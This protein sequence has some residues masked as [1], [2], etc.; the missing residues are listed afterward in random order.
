MWIRSILFFLPFFISVSLSANQNSIQGNPYPI[1]AG[2]PWQGTVPGSIAYTS[3]VNSA[4]SRIYNV[5]I[6]VPEG[7]NGVQPSLFL[8]YNNLQA[9]STCG[10]GWMLS[11]LSYITRANKSIHFDQYA[12]AVYF[13]RDDAFS[14]D[15]KRLI[16]LADNGDNIEYETYIGKIRAKAYL[17]GSVVKYFEV[18]YPDGKMAVF[19]EK[20]NTSNLVKYDVTS[21]SDLLGNTITYD[22]SGPSDERLI[23]A[24][25]YNHS[26]I[27]FD[28]TQRSDNSFT[29]KNGQMFSITKLLKS[30]S[31]IFDGKK[32]SE[33]SL[34][35]D[36]C[37]GRTFLKQIDYIAGGQRLNPLI[38]KYGTLSGQN[39]FSTT[40]GSFQSY[41]T[42]DDSHPLRAVKGRFM[43]GGK[44]EGLAVFPAKGYH[45][46]LHST[47]FRK[48]ITA[49]GI[50][51]EGNEDIYIYPSLS[52]DNLKPKVIKA[53]K[54]FVDLM[55]VNMGGSQRE[56]LVKINDNTGPS[57]A[58]YFNYIK[59]KYYAIDNISNLI[60]NLIPSDSVVFKT[61]TLFIDENKNK[62][63]VPKYFYS[64]D[65][66]GDG[67]LES[68]FVSVH[69]P[70]GYET[71]SYTG[72]FS[73]KNKE[74]VFQGETLELYECMTGSE[75]ER[76]NNSDKLLAI[77]ID[78]D[79]K[80]DLCHINKNGVA[81]HT[82][83]ALPRKAMSHRKF[84]ESSDIKLSD[85]ADKQIYV[86]DFNADGLVD[87]LVS[88]SSKSE[89]EQWTIYYSK[90]NG[91][92]H[93]QIV[94]ITRY[95]PDDFKYILSDVD[96]D[97][98]PDLIK[99]NDATFTSYIGIGRLSK[100]TSI[101]TA[102]CFRGSMLVPVEANSR[103]SFVDL[104]AIK[105]SHYSRYSF[106]HNMGNE[107][108]L[109]YMCG[110][111]GLIEK[112]AYARTTDKN[113]P[114]VEKL[115]TPGSGAIFPY[116]NFDEPIPVVTATETFVE[117]KSIDFRSYQYENAV[118]H[119]Q[120]L[121]FLGFAKVIENAPEGTSVKCYD[122]KL[123][124]SLVSETTPKRRLENRYNFR[125]NWENN[126]TA[127]LQL[128]RSIETN[129]ATE[130]SDTT[131][132]IYNYYSNTL[133]ESR[134]NWWDGFKS[135]SWNPYLT[136]DKTGPGYTQGC[137]P[138][139]NNSWSESG[140]QRRYMRNEY[141]DSIWN[142]LPLSA[143]VF[144][145]GTIPHRK[146]YGY[147]DNGNMTSETIIFGSET[148]ADSLTTTYTYDKYG[149]VT[150]EIDP[151]GR[152]TVAYE[153][154]ENGRMCKK[155]DADNVVSVL[156]YDGLGRITHEN[157]SD[158][159]ATSNYY[160]W[161]GGNN[162]HWSKI[163]RST[164]SPERTIVYDSQGRAVKSMEK[165]FDGRIVAV[166]T[167]FDQA[168]R[169][170][171][172]SCPYYIDERNEPEYWR[173]T[174]EYD[175]FDRV[176]AH[177]ID[178]I[179]VEKNYYERN[180]VTTT[181]LGVTTKRSYD[182]QGNLISVTDASGSVQ[183]SYNSQCKPIAIKHS[184]TGTTTS[185]E[186]DEYGNNIVITDPN[187][188][189]TCRTYD[190]RGRLLTE[191][192]AAGRLTSY[193]Y[194]SFDRVKKI[195]EDGRIYT[196][197]Y[198]KNDRLL[199][200]DKSIRGYDQFG[201]LKQIIHFSDSST[202]SIKYDYKNGNLSKASY[203]S[204]L[205]LKATEN[206]LYSNGHLKAI[207]LNNADTIYSILSEDVFGRVTK[208]QSGQ[209][210]K[211]Y[212]YDRYGMPSSRVVKG[213]FFYPLSKFEVDSI[214]LDSI[215]DIFKPIN[216]GIGTYG[217][218]VPGVNPG[219]EMQQFLCTHQNQ[220]YK[221][222]PLRKTLIERS[223]Y[224]GS[225]G[226]ENFGYDNLNRLVTHGEHTV[227]YDSGGNILSRS[228]VG[229]LY[230]GSN[231]SPFAVTSVDFIQDKIPATEQYVEYTTRQR[232]IHITNGEYTA[233]WTY[234][235]SGSR[236]SMTV[237]KCEKEILKKFYIA[238]CYEALFENGVVTERL[239]L[240]GDY[241]ESPVVLQY[242]QDQNEKLYLIRDYLGSIIKVLGTLSGTPQTTGYDPW[243][244][245]NAGK[246]DSLYI[247]RGFTGHEH[248]PWF[249]LI[250]MNARLYDPT[251]G[252]FLSPDP[253]V[254]AP[255][256]PQNFNRYSYCLNNPLAYID[257]DGESIL[258]LILGMAVFQGSMNLI[259]NWSSIMNAGGGWDSFVK[260][261]A[262]FGV[263]AAAG[264]A[265]AGI[266]S[267]FPIAGISN[268]TSA[269]SSIAKSGFMTAMSSG[270]AIGATSGFITGFGNSL[271]SGESMTTS[272][273]NGLKSGLTSGL[274]GA[275]LNGLLSGF[276]ALKEGRNF[277]SGKQSSQKTQEIV[278]Q[279]NAP[280]PPPAYGSAKPPKRTGK[281]ATSI[282]KDYQYHHMMTDKNLTYTPKFEK[283]IAPLNLK[284]NESWNIWYMPHR[285]SHPIEYHEWVLDHVT[286]IMNIKNITRDQFIIEF[287]ERVVKPVM[288][289]PLMLRKIHWIN[290]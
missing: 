254:Q 160:E 177:Y 115:Y 252:R 226:K 110:S 72:I 180:S 240:G 44:E 150:S 164:E 123:L 268:V 94:N 98:L 26:E 34:L 102:F 142:G 149:H 101:S 14:L 43:Y 199:I 56:M 68:L 87:L 41:H 258:P 158:T 118:G 272:L 145:Y 233:G 249:G 70:L 126:N 265:E 95:Q 33:Y 207:L 165:R 215:S 7:I 181:S 89:S 157:R 241:Y 81:C 200:A 8:S 13:E 257:K 270:A 213:P 136:I 57:S 63:I 162:R 191:T 169:V 65:F 168:G 38:F 250:N 289:D 183:Y 78:G 117:G 6:G 25:R 193:D 194:D 74:V 1:D 262:Y 281:M 238:D 283:A 255:D 61:Q 54:G 232:P 275:A 28:Y 161:A 30:I 176:L 279:L 186:Y 24:I 217:L 39:I 22:Y 218:T 42:M 86:G 52:G 31:V 179:C 108:M 18:F 256:M 17:S 19:G 159:T 175:R 104:I 9:N 60:P 99:Y 290:K 85:L 236:T 212:T 219:W 264:A 66:D 221:F 222:D 225:S 211:T 121:G 197:T 140:K 35:Y 184:S 76:A 282:P 247:G 12:S 92:F 83:I 235:S 64:G 77:D 103:T 167:K 91:R 173:E 11:G 230:Y 10:R 259:T 155:T 75:R 4:G 71:N 182:S 69:K 166:D 137:I 187:S 114:Y 269:A 223:G 198:D 203:I 112:T 204:S 208:A 146:L 129:Q 209:L 261:V 248:L 125:W 243:G 105:D 36:T 127:T 96:S 120:G 49:F 148:E 67:Y 202:L 147:D 132:Y 189:E 205:G 46:H 151:Y 80:T 122:A 276:T 163:E 40:S 90:G 171:A 124:N 195:T 62:S 131:I 27:K 23:S 244:N 227:E 141:I 192:D 188:G 263:G 266:S 237:S 288:D 47:W 130:Y 196:F 134:K 278:A 2:A 138:E 135:G 116:V 50:G 251:L 154:D 100:P 216:P 32:T 93:R 231:A 174:F 29:F 73:L 88:P 128:T 107:G 172:I 82:F 260:G 201:R 170:S 59:F 97:G 45:G 144:G 228:D 274:T 37:D 287:T 242:K 55:T 139:F 20:T 79:G 58:K 229:N 178:S 153:Y 15:G 206:Y 119:R 109:T 5:P 133:N 245:I 267:L 53:E 273:S 185:F 51:Y 143:D 234:N 246:S 106:N 284:L 285:G 220:T 210:I 271:I 253:Y 156:T 84:A 214:P 224:P 111:L 239:Y 113:T 280:D 16:M 277:W 3:E 48:S 190:N 152:R 21:Y 286:N